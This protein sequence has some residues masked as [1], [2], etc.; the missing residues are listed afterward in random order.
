MLL[1][2]MKKHVNISFLIVHKRVLS[3]AG[4]FAMIMKLWCQEK[5]KTKK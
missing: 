5:S 3:A 2:M 1:A 4:I